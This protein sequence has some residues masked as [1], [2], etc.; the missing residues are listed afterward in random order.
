M[1]KIGQAMERA[2]FPSCDSYDL[3]SSTK[4]FPDGTHYRVELSGIETPKVLVAAIDEAKKQG[5]PFH[6]SVSVVRGASMLTREEL[7]EFARI[8]HDNEV[9]VIMTPGPRPTWY[10]GRQIAT[11]EGAISGLRMRGMETVKHYLMDLDRCVN[12]G[13]RGFL[14]WDEGVLSLLD[15][16]KRNGDLPLDVIFKVSVFAGH[17]NAAGVKLV[18]SLGAG[19]CNPVADLTL[20][21]LAS[22]RKVVNLP[23][24]VH[25]Q[26]WTSMGGYNRIYETPDIA[27]VTSPCYFKMEPGPGLGMYMPWGTSEDGLAELAREK[28]RSTKNIIELIE[29]VQPE[30]RV[31]KH[32]AED[33]MVPLPAR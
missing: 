21:Q 13:F 3:P 10:I 12:I 17:A 11:P 14:V 24:D 22:I 28:I 6:R 15:T 32:G 30:L 18:E 8:A 19:S 27:R 29:E 1:D 7:K 23:L 2:G 33:L 31:S 9:E 25:I 4:T 5:V 26:L 20:P 16:M